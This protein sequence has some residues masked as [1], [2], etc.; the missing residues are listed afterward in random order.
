MPKGPQFVYIALQARP[1]LSGSSLCQNRIVYQNPQRNAFGKLCR[2]I[3]YESG[4]YYCLNKIY[5]GSVNLKTE[6]LCTLHR[7]FQRRRKV[8]TYLIALLAPFAPSCYV[9]IGNNSG[10]W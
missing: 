6:L 5:W 9:K 8:G 10:A 1:K 3:A 7:I 4:D 2:L